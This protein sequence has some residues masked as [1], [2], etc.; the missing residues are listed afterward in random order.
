MGFAMALEKTHKPYYEVTKNV[1]SQ[2]ESGSRRKR[3]NKAKFLFVKMVNYLLERLA[4]NCPFNSWRVKFHKW[5][6]V[7][8]GKNVMI[9]F[10]VTLDHSYPEYITIEDDVSLAGNNYL[11]A[12]SNPYP[13]FKNV[14]ESFAAPVTIKKGAWIGIGAMILPDV[15]VGEYSIISAGSVVHKNIPPRVIAGGVPAKV[16]KEIDLGGL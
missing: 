8:I 6:G 10:Q 15:T 14:L 7:N 2:I 5:R 4:Y 3:L 12:H 1:R 9:G 11:L 16:I 13:H